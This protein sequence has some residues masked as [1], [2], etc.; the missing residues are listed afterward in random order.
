MPLIAEIISYI[1]LTRH[2]PARA[3]DAHRLD[4]ITFLA[5]LV[6]TPILKLEVFVEAHRRRFRAALRLP[7]HLPLKLSAALVARFRRRALILAKAA[8]LAHPIESVQIIHRRRERP[9]IFDV[10]HHD[11]V[12][13]LTH[14]AM[15]VE[16]HHPLRFRQSRRLVGRRPL[17]D[18]DAVIDHAHARVIFERRIGPRAV[19]DDD[20]ACVALYVRQHIFDG[21]LQKHLVSARDQHV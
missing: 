7:D 15:R 9:V 2:H 19:R 12:K 8:R 4:A 18:A 1:T 17:A 16:L 3:Q 21:A 20:D 14:R 5:A 13:A 6:L 10:L 11:A